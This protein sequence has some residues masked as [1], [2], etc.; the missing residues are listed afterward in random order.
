ML[1]LKSDS[2][3][4]ETDL[5]PEVV[6]YYSRFYYTPIFP[7]TAP[8]KYV[9]E[10]NEILTWERLLQNCLKA[11]RQ[12]TSFVLSSSG[13]SINILIQ[14]RKLVISATPKEEHK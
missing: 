7:S 3:W 4:L 6:A 9:E 5:I 8:Q 10:K 14:R 2:E 12:L 11:L 1:Y 13:V